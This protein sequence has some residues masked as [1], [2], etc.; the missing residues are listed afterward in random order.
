MSPKPL[1][2]RQYFHFIN[3]Y[4]L[5]SVT[6]EYNT[7]A[8]EKACSDARNL[9]SFVAMNNLMASNSPHQLILNLDATVYSVGGEFGNKTRA[10]VKRET[11]SNKVRKTYKVSASKA[12]KGGTKYFI[13]YYIC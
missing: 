7:D 2:K 13:K 12:S 4:K 11:S 10:V 1:N 3:E 5:K 9:A 6:A 8:R